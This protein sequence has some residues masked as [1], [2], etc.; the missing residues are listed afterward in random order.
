LLNGFPVAAMQ[1]FVGPDELKSKLET[2]Y[3]TVQQTSAAS[4][5]QP[6]PAAASGGLTPEEVE[7]HKQ[8]IKEKLKQL[9]DKKSKEE[10]QAELEREKRR[11]EDG[12]LMFETQQ[13]LKEAKELREREIE[14]K[15][16]EEERK[17]QERLREQI[18]IEKL[19]RQQK[20]TT[21]SAAASVPQSTSPTTSKKS[22][23]ACMIRVRLF[24]GELASQS[25][26]ANEK[27][28][29]VREWIASLTGKIKF[30]MS[31]NYPAKVFNAAGTTLFLPSPLHWS[32]Q[33]LII[34]FFHVRYVKDT[35]RSWIGAEC[36]YHPFRDRSFG[37]YAS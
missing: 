17:Y 11:R 36:K 5:T 3:Q 26:P 35:F 29:A 25:F 37:R 10:E 6:E 1:G 9:R 32:S 22:D 24:S 8:R 15:K 31:T 18:R 12:K 34:I 7:A 30:V 16:K 27:L 33:I 23:S 28:A 13:R 14:A 4:S 19:E 20:S 21:S 2:A